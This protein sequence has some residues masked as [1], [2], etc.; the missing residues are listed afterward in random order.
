MVERG[1]M[2]L[3]IIAILLKRQILGLISEDSISEADAADADPSQNP[4]LRAAAVPSRGPL[5]RRCERIAPVALHGRCQVPSVGAAKWHINSSDKLDRYNGNGPARVPK[6][7]GE[8]G[9]PLD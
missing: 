2:R 7:V 9:I 1:G 3:D 4:L 6:T 5:R 8:R